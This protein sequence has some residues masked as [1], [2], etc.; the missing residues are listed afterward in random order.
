MTKR[1]AC[2]A[3][4]AAALV[5]FALPAVPASALCL[6]EEPTIGFFVCI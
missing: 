3:A 2:L 5:T 6:I 1:F 4:I